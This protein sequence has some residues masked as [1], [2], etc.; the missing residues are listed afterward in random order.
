MPAANIQ[1]AVTVGSMGSSSREAET[2]PITSLAG[3]FAEIARKR[4]SDVTRFR[5][6][7]VDPRASK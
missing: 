5:T 7:C 6:C 3:I 2:V 4:A 1:L